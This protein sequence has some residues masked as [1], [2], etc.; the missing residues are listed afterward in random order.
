MTWRALIIGGFAAACW[1]ITLAAQA[2]VAP[3]CCAIVET[4]PDIMSYPT[5]GSTV[6]DGRDSTYAYTDLSHTV[7]AD[8]DLL[9]VFVTGYAGNGNDI[10]AAGPNTNYAVNGIT[11]TKSGESGQSMTYHYP[12]TD[13]EWGAGEALGIY[14]LVNPNIGAGTISFGSGNTQPS[15]GLHFVAVNVANV[16]TA[17]GTNGIRDTESDSTN[18]TNQSCNFTITSSA[19]DIV[20]SSVYAYQDTSITNNADS[21]LYNNGGATYNNTYNEVWY[22][23]ATTSSTVSQTTGADYPAMFGLSIAGPSVQNV[24]VTATAIHVTAQ[25]VG[26]GKVSVNYPADPI[27]ATASLAG[28]A[29]TA[30]SVSF[31]ADPVT[32]TASLAGL[33]V[34]SVSTAA[35]AIS[36]GASLSGA[37]VIGA[38]VAA[39]P[40]I[41]AASLIGAA[42]IGATVAADAILASASVQGSSVLSVSA[43]PTPLTATASLSGA[44]DTSGGAVIVADPIVSTA[45]LVGQSV[46]DVLIT[47]GAIPATASVIGSSVITVSAP[48]DPIAAAASIAGT[49]V[50]AVSVLADPVAATA[51]LAGAASVSGVVNIVASPI[52][53]T[54]S[55][56]GSSVLSV[57]TA[58]DPIASSAALSGAPQISATAL[59]DAISAVSSILGFA[60]TSSGA[61]IAADPL[62]ATASVAGS[63]VIDVVVTADVLSVL[64]Q[65]AGTAIAVG[66]IT[67]P[68]LIHPAYIIIDSRQIVDMTPIRDIE[69]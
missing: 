48:A 6:S 52:V 40:V 5:I 41:S 57:A 49:P 25:A 37:S 45:S 29:E 19:N 60:S 14:S 26:A 4:P 63:S 42:H 47:A 32:A 28:T 3:Y 35:T 24:E 39:D 9:I 66:P 61:V 13:G 43:T 55:L 46:I 22:T 34:L 10:D 8:T 16:D 51:S 56:G 23:E 31:P 12:P 21:I 59:A 68:A 15:E 18:G 64:S 62:S 67:L 50:I 65:L 44:A 30:T 53:A 36:A 2:L 58:A 27:T 38:S 1:L 54:A 33:S 69:A 20:L 17:I 7:D 11:W